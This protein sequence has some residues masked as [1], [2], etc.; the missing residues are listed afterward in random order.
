MIGE[1]PKTLEVGNVEYDIRTDFRDILNV[2]LAFDDP[3]LDE[4][5]KAYVCLYVIYID[6]EKMPPK[7]YKEAIKKA[8]EFIDHGSSKNKKKSPR[9]MD[10]EQDESILFP[11]INKAAGFEVREK[12]YIHWW[13]FMG[14]YLE[15][16]EGVFSHVVSIRAKKKK[17]KKLEKWEQEF[18]NANQDII[19]LKPKLSDEDLAIKERLDK[20]TRGE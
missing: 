7:D 5:E 17:G 11:A 14:Y 1:L 8:V 18:Y 16:Q 9:V 13:T 6:F 3:N 12:P 4:S 2:L 20:L 19:K 10:W 15:I